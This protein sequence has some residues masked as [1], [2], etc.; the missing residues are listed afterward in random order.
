MVKHIAQEAPRQNQ[1]IAG[2][3]RPAIP[4]PAFASGPQW[5]DAPT[6]GLRPDTSIDTHPAGSGRLSI[7][8]NAFKRLHS[9]SHTAGILHFI[10]KNMKSYF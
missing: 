3:L 2:R 7:N 8:S 4:L 1:R 5:I 6:S 10:C 9:A